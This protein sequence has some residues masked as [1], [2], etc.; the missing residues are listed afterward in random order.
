MRYFIFI[1]I[2]LGPSTI[3]CQKPF[4]DSIAYKNWPTVIGGNISG[5]GKYMLYSI[6]KQPVKSRTLVVKSTKD[7]WETSFVGIRSAFFSADSK[8]VIFKNSGDSLCIVRLGGNKI[9]FI[10]NIGNYAIPIKGSGEWLAYNS[11]SEKKVLYLLNR[12]TGERIRFDS[13]VNFWFAP[14]GRVLYL[15]LDDKESSLMKL[16]C[17]NFTHG[18]RRM[19][20]KG[21]TPFDF[22]FDT[23]GRQMVFMENAQPPINDIWYYS[24]GSDSCIELANAKN[25]ELDSNLTI[26]GKTLY[27]N[28]S[29]SKVFFKLV[30]KDK[31]RIHKS[32]NSRVDIWKYSD[33]FLTTAESIEESDL[34]EYLAVINLPNRS[35]QIAK[36]KYAILRL[37]SDSESLAS[38]LNVSN[39]DFV[40]CARK[41]ARRDGTVVAPT[42]VVVSTT[43][44]TRRNLFG[45]KDK[46]EDEYCF[47]YPSPNGK[48][49]AFFD[50]NKRNYFSWEAA[51]GLVRN[52]T[53][54]IRVEWLDENYTDL[55][56]IL[57]IPV[58]GV[59]GWLNRDSTVMIYDNN[60]IWEID[61]N[62]IRVANN[63]TDSYGRTHQIRFRIAENRDS[64]LLLTAFNLVT[65][66]SGFFLQKI[67]NGNRLEQLTMGPYNYGINP[68]SNR[69]IARVPVKAQFADR[70]LVMRES[71][72]N[73]PNFLVTDNFKSFVSVSDCQPE[74]KF[75]WLN[76]ELINWKSSDGG[77]L[78]G[79]IFKPENFDEKKKY[80]IIILVYEQW[81]N[82]LYEFPRPAATS[83]R[84]NIPYFVSR[85]YLVLTP[86]IHYKI[87]KTGQSSL[88]SVM[89][90]TDYL[91]KFKWLDSSKMAIC[92]HSFGGYET[93]YIVTHTQRFAAALSASGVSDL[94]SFYGSLDLMGNHF[95]NW[96]ENTQGR[97][98]ST[99]WESQDRFI[100]NSPI[101][102][103][104]KV[105]TPLLLMNNKMDR[106][107]PFGQG[108]EMFL[109][110]RRLNKKAWLLQYDNGSHS[111]GE[112]DAD[113]FTIRVTQ[114]FDHYLKNESAP[115][116][117]TGDPISRLNGYG[118]GKLK[119]EP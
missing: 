52:I 30:E 76:A 48:Y 95:G 10:A 18:D 47:F 27:F 70:W 94:V 84:I 81:S 72:N 114:F 75:N 49:I 33:E 1:L 55:P 119:R 63:L 7:D 34:K 78:S 83:D 102:Y 69:M 59:A 108:V 67:G 19:V 40:V 28:K 66:F 93:N 50:Y 79:V 16:E 21:H 99:L 43:D 24:E 111:L 61:P 107:S 112:L 100:V 110:L 106:T 31:E 101:F 88:N 17:Y 12:L 87:G 104:D 44:G 37:E 90:A 64:S 15:Q 97:I 11:K 23:S 38:P 92:G 115:L 4:I 2:S 13:V 86:D 71:F 118:D 109:A 53:N 85:G 82:D 51:T 5:D 68:Y 29:A 14:S 60:D 35:E 9:D 73:A 45:R 96:I 103:A 89:E 65:K 3:F 74:R 6:D 58:V 32:G 8:S 22:T 46:V 54:G 98:G 57:S 91:S 36:V 62:C 42:Y 116:W 117:M 41:G 105:T 77:R 80:P 56:R 113:D 25:M 20:W 26:S 39:D